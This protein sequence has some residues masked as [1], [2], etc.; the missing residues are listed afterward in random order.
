MTPPREAIG[1][2]PEKALTAPYSPI[3]RH[4]DLLFVSGQVAIGP[5][6]RIVEGGI[7][8]QTEQALTNLASV[9]EQAGSGL[10]RL[11]KCNVFLADLGDWAAMNEVWIRRIGLPRPARCAVGAGLPDGMLIEVDAIAAAGD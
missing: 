7:A 9:L 2:D 1:I 6:G 4:G 5:D 10:D 3:L 8:E 11:L